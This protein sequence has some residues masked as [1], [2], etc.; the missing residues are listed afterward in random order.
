MYDTRPRLATRAKYRKLSFMSCDAILSG[1]G[2]FMSLSGTMGELGTNCCL[3]SRRQK[4]GVLTEQPGF[5]AV[6]LTDPLHPK[7][8]I[9]NNQLPKASRL[10]YRCVRRRQGKIRMKRFEPVKAVK[11]VTCIT[12][13]QNSCSSSSQ[14]RRH[15]YST[16]IFK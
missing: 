10:V 13:N 7:R 11:S 5:G 15:N 9:Q 12:C 14:R 4:N 16:T 1:Q 8:F 3:S 2:W 6:F